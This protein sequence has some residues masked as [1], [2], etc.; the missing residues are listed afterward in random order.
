MSIIGPEENHLK[1]ST[2]FP[3]KCMGTIQINAQGSKL[4]FTVKKVKHQ[5]TTIILAILVDLLFQMICAKIQPQGILE[6]KIFKCFTIYGHGGH[7]SQWTTTYSAI[8][9]S[10]ALRRLHMKSEQI[11]SA[12]SEEKLS[13]NVNGWMQ[14]CT[15]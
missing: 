15:D 3:Y 2:F 12:A 1:F 14:V 10:L 4:D 7:L 5:H 8:I 11:G 13:E 6:K 9:R